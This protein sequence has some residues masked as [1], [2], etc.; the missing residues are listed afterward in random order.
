MKSKI[1]R[2][3][4]IISVI[5]AAVILVLVYS[6]LGTVDLVYMQ[7]NREIYRQKDVNVLSDIEIPEGDFVYTSGDETKPIQ[8]EN[9]LKKDICITVL[10][11]LVTFKWNELDYVIT[12]KA[13]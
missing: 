6:L 3:A 11:N 10:T 13:K 4:G 2:S 9:E 5:V 12:F 1:P 7:D 8:D